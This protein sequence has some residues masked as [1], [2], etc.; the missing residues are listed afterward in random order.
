MPQPWS[1]TLYGLQAS[2]NSVLTIP[3]GSRSHRTIFPIRRFRFRKIQWLAEDPS[4]SEGMEQERGLGSAWLPG[5]LTSLGIDGVLVKH[6]ES[7]APPAPPEWESVGWGL[8]IC[9]FQKCFRLILYTHKYKNTSYSHSLRTWEG[10]KG[11]YW[12]S[13]QECAQLWANKDEHSLPLPTPGLL[14]PSATKEQIHH[15]IQWKHFHRVL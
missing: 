11:H 7:R 3:R 6:T 13:S 10:R 5:P 1:R 9:I 14:P 8:G 15:W 4:P 2:S 12:P